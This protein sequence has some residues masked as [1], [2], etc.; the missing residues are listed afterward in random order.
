MPRRASFFE[1]NPISTTTTPEHKKSPPFAPQEQGRGFILSEVAQKVRCFPERSLEMDRFIKEKR[2][3]L[4]TFLGR[5]IAGVEDNAIER[6]DL[7]R[8]AHERAVYCQSED[9]IIEI[10]SHDEREIFLTSLIEALM[11][12]TSVRSI[13]LVC[14]TM[15]DF[16]AEL[17]ARQLERNTNLKHLELYACELTDVGAECLSRLPQ[18][19]SGKLELVLREECKLSDQEQR[20]LAAKGRVRVDSDYM[21]EA[22]K[23]TKG[24]P[25]HLPLHR[26][27]SAPDVHAGFSCSPVELEEEPPI[28]HPLALRPG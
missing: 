13:R 14:I 17:L 15:T 25:E 6:I 10:I 28:K 20:I 18:V 19:R 2:E 21:D 12:N 8:F 16:L 24:T 11:D 5:V 26:S 1:P 22:S 3:K 9:E 23:E 4:L 7:L 27:W